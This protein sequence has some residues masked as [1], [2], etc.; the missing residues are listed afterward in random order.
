MSTTNQPGKSITRRLSYHP[1]TAHNLPHPDEAE[2]RAALMERLSRSEIYLCT[3]IGALVKA[4]SLA[5]DPSVDSDGHTWTTPEHV[6]EWIVANIDDPT[7]T[8]C[9]CSTGVRCVESGTTYTCLDDDCGCRFDRETALEV[10][11]A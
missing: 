1:Q 6:H 3:S 2:P 8:P 10:L 9:G 11:D 7:T 4:E 5:E